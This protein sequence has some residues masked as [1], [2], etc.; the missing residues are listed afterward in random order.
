MKECEIA[1][2]KMKTNKS[3]GLDGLTTEFYQTFWHIIGPLV[4]DSFNES[5]ENE[6]LSWSQRKSVLSLIYKKGDKELI[7]NYRP[8]SLTNVDYRLLAFTLTGRLQNVI[9]SIVSTDQSAYIKKRFMGTNIRLVA[10]IIEYFDNM[11]YNGVLMTVDFQKAFD[12]VDWNFLFKTLQY[13]NFGPSF[14]KWIKTIYKKP[15][16][17]I[18]NNGYMSSFF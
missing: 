9:D 8:I 14:I 15:E 17:C 2:F 3:P 10:D 16:A 12:S 5:F 7:S 1:L 13:F 4:V 18:K 6:Q 11:S